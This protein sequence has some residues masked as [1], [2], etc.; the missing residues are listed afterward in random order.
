M[1]VRDDGSSKGG[2]KGSSNDSVRYER[3]LEF[4]FWTLAWDVYTLGAVCLKQ[5]DHFL[6]CVFAFRVSFVCPR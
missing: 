3:K 6:C 1:Q 4:P 5:V 2:G